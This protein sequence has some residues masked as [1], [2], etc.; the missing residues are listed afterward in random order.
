MRLY[1]LL[2]SSFML[3]TPLPLDKEGALLANMPA[4]IEPQSLSDRNADSPDSVFEVFPLAR[5]LH[6]VYQY[7]YEDYSTMSSMRIGGRIDSGVVMN[8]IRDSIGTS[9]TRGEGDYFA[10]YPTPGYKLISGSFLHIP[11]ITEEE[12]KILFTCARSLN[13]YTEDQKKETCYPKKRLKSIVRPGD[14]FNE[15]GDISPV[16]KEAGWKLVFTGK[17]KVQHW[18]RP[19]KKEGTSATF[20]KHDNMFYVFSSNCAPLDSEKWYTKF[21]LLSIVSYGGGYTDAAK[22]LAEQGYGATIVAEAE[23]LLTQF[24][25]FR[26]NVVTGRVEYREKGGKEFVVVQDYN[27]NSI[28]RKLNLSHIPIGADPLARLLKSE[29]APQFDPFKEYYESLPAWD[30]QTD[31]IAQLAD[32]VV[33]KHPQ[34]QQTWREYLMKWMVAAVGCAIDPNINNQ[35]CLTLVGP[36][37]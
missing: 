3:A 24:F 27:L 30:Q 18:R 23:T 28:C 16:L 21:A 34:E 35:T 29:F 15:R 22:D 12:R 10:S 32:T 8:T 25:D 31:Y 37:G 17:D 26:F 6:S 20:N 7:R 1:T 33:L 5:G 13:R 2:F 14:D 4:E 11:E 9:E 19:G 36:Q